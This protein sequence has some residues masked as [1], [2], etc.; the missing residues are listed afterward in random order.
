MGREHN[1]TEDITS[2]G[3]A[4]ACVQWV[5]P[6]VFLPSQHPLALLICTQ[7]LFGKPFY[8]TV[9]VSYVAV[10]APPLTPW[11]PHDLGVSQ[12][13]CFLPLATVIGLDGFLMRAKP[14]DISPG[15]LPG[16]I[17]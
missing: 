1:T 2:A 4:Q 14:T 10:E 16:T 13:E 6:T 15:T 12:S 9:F 5:L 7:V 3:T 11:Q 17:S 8:P